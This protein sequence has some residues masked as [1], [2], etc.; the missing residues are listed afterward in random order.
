M[1]ESESLR[2]GED[3]LIFSLLVLFWGNI[4][5]SF[6]PLKGWATLLFPFNKKSFDDR[7]CFGKCFGA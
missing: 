5:I 6:A 2:S 4:A 3:L 7:E 1:R